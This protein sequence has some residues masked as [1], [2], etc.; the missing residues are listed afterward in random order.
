M[1]RRDFLLF[2]REGRERTLELSCER[3]YMRWADARSGLGQAHAEAG[4]DPGSGWWI[5]EPPTEV[6]S[7][8]VEEVLADLESGLANVEVLRV[9]DSGWLMD[10]EFR[11]K[12]EAVFD[13]FRARGGMVRLLDAS[14][15]AAELE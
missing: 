1:N 14:P 12:V 11:E 13:R 7:S 10:G 2:R 3:L 4:P 9:A 15:D 6:R 8:G 5:G